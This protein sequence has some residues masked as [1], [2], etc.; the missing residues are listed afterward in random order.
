[1]FQFGEILDTGIWPSG[2]LGPLPDRYGVQTTLYGTVNYWDIKARKTG[3]PEYQ[4]VRNPSS[5]TSCLFAIF[6][7][8]NKAA[9]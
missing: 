7:T 4:A 2:V 1:M 8:E 5:P 3:G 6:K 9:L